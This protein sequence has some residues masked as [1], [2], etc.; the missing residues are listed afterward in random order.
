LEGTMSDYKEI[1]EKV[2][3]ESGF[4]LDS[5][6]LSKIWFMLDDLSFPDSDYDTLMSDISSMR[7]ALACEYGRD[8]GT[9][10]DWT[11]GVLEMVDKF[12]NYTNDN[13]DE[14]IEFLKY[15]YISL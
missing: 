5:T 10:F 3:P 11:E 9:D 7:N 2:N 13:L 1:V 15:R 12:D 14:L 4:N 8:Y 6:D